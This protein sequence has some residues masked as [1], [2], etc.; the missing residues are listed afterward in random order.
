MET[1]AELLHRFAAT[2]DELAFRKLV[3]RH[4]GMVYG[5]ALRIV[6]DAAMAEEIAQGVTK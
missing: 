1:D 2:A 4:A 3:E 5:V 6:G